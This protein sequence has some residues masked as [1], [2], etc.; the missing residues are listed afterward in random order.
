MK[1][2]RA[3]PRKVVVFVT[4][5][6]TLVGNGQYEMEKMDKGLKCVGNECCS[7]VRWNIAS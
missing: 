6:F 2:H 5:D 7:T 4:G 1:P 3:S